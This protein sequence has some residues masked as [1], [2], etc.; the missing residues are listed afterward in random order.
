MR[1]WVLPSLIIMAGL[2]LCRSS[3]LG[4][5]YIDIDSPN[6]RRTQIAVTEFQSLSPQASPTFG[7]SLTEKVSK[8]L[9]ITGFFSP[10][11]TQA[12]LEKPGGRIDFSN[13][14]AIGAE[15]LI[16]GTYVAEGP[17]FLIEMRLYDVVKG[18]VI[19]AN[20][21]SGTPVDQ[22]LIARQIARDV[23]E[24]LSGEGGI[25][26]TSLALVVKKGTGSE[27]GIVNFDGTDYVEITRTNSITLSPRFSP[28]GRYL[29]FMS[30]KNKN[31]HLFIY[32]VKTGSTRLLSSTPGLNLPGSWSPDGK[33]I[34][35]TLSVDGNEEI[36]AIEV[37]TGKRK[38]LTYNQDIDVSPVFSP[39]GKSIAFVSD[40]S[41]TPQIF[42]MNSDGTNVR[43]LTFYGNYNTSPAW[44]PRGD[45]I[46][47]EGRKEGIFQI[48]SI[49]PGGGEPLQITNGPEHRSP[50]WSPDGRFIAATVVEGV[51]EK[52]TI[53]NLNGNNQRVL[54]PGSQPNWSPVQRR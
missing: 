30:Y 24:A 1:K 34:L 37:A 17:R 18:E 38:R 44:S 3:V 41:G 35:A 11:P 40:R 4:R 54:L 21:Y 53:M 39:D 10:I 23:L 33:M 22:T 20:R 42:I 5:I 45:R 13:W 7:P 48:F 49:S 32:D 52:I 29:A 43:R 8:L 9:N 6:Y 25:F 16:A 50:A 51:K 19:K 2:I 36:Y 28:D 26:F 47:Y 46:L 14:S 12:F 27:I 15:Y 31:P